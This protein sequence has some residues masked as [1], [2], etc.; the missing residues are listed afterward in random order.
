MQG[1]ILTDCQHGAVI[2]PDDVFHHDHMGNDEHTVQDLHD[3]LQSYYKVA[4]KTFVD[5]LRKQAADHF[6]ISGADTPLTLFSP[7]FVAKLSEEELEEAAGEDRQVKRHR[8]AL[9]KEAH[10]LDEARK[11]LR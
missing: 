4:R 11:I 7:S 8:A 5:N 10:D 9:E 3:I 1:K 6:L 2:R